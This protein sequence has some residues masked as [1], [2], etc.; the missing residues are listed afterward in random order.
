MRRSR[1]AQGHDLLPTAGGHGRGRAHDS[2]GLH[3]LGLLPSRRGARL[4][5]GGDAVDCG[6][7]GARAHQARG[8][9]A[10][11]GHDGVLGE[12]R[13]RRAACD[14]RAHGGRAH[15]AR[16]EGSGEQRRPM[17]R[18]PPRRRFAGAGARFGARRARVGRRPVR[19]LLALACGPRRRGA[20]RRADG[21][22]PGTVGERRRL[23]RGRR[24]AA[25]PR[26]RLVRLAARQQPRARRLPRRA[27]VYAG[28]RA[29]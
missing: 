14:G 26:A 16:S 19:L 23:G 6:R 24:R 8:V 18:A 11:A 7:A 3:A 10:S 21:G 27:R 5:Q 25:Q 15:V 4:P 17:E 28:H 2:D 1:P 22:L 29:V 9:R 20:A 13:R 12:L